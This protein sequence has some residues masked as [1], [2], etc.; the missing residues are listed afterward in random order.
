MCLC[1]HRGCD[2][3]DKCARR[4]PNSKTNTEAET[5]RAGDVVL[6]NNLILL[7]SEILK[8]HKDPTFDQIAKSIEISRGTASVHMRSGLIW[9]FCKKSS[10]ANEN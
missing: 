2:S 5:A 1:S 7:D 3:R 8:P 6:D 10:P 9:A 4:Q